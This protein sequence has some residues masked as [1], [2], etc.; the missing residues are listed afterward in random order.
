MAAVADVV[1]IGGGIVGVS[2]AAHLAAVGVRSSLWSGRPSPPGRPGRNS[3]VVQHPFDRVLVDLHLE[4]IALYRAL[5]ERDPSAF[6]LGDRPVGL[7]SVTH[8]ADAARH[9]TAEWADTHPGLTPTYLSPDE[10]RRLEPTIAPGI[11]ACRIEIGYPVAPDAATHAYAAWA[12]ALGAT[13]RI[14]QGARPWWVGSDLRGAV[15][16][17]GTTIAARDVVVAAGPASPT[18][19]DPS[20]VW[21]PIRPIWGVVVSAAF[22]EPPTHVLEELGIKIEP[23]DAAAGPGVPGAADAADTAAARA[24]RLPTRAS[25]SAWSRPVRRVRWDRPSWRTNRT[26]ARCSRG[27]SPTARASSPP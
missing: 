6:R 26:P 11:A 3:G 5:G 17:D 18:L 23:E 10:V 7:L 27:S 12:T 19:I 9:E 20:S 15:L 24:T 13:I 4:T 14:G 1:V 22:P 16:D 8:D 2:A 21:C 25:R